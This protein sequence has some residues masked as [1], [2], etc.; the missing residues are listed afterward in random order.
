MPYRS[1]LTGKCASRRSIF[2]G[3][4]PAGIRPLSTTAC[5]F[6][7]RAQVA[8]DEL[9]VLS[10]VVMERQD[11]AL[12]TV[13]DETKQPNEDMD[14]TTMNE[15]EKPRDSSSAT[16]GGSTIETAQP[17]GGH[18]STMRGE[19]REQQAS[20]PATVASLVEGHELE[21]HL[22]TA[23]TE[24]IYEAL[25]IVRDRRRTKDKRT[26]AALVKHLLATGTAPN[27]FIYET[28][29][30][31]HADPD[32]SA[33]TVKTLLWEMR[34]NM[35]PWSS[36]AYHAAL[37]VSPATLGNLEKQAVLTGIF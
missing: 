4:R 25:R 11:A 28:V 10:D 14:P 12:Q 20:S 22:T 17:R 27:T 2:P 23:T 6:Q 32:G 21:D 8:D 13:P 5:P 34:D 15:A 36:T 16:L 18:I 33:D 9:G 3:H 19:S 29:L 24:D 31:A 37:R 35:L 7:D 26:T 1:Q 30:M